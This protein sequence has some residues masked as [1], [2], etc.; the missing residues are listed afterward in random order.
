MLAGSFYVLAKPTENN[1]WRM[2]KITSPYL[3]MLFLG[4]IID[5]AL[6]G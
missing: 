5:V 1:A 2:F 4:M 3:F 6:R